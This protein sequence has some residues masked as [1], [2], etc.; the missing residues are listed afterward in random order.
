M[1]STLLTP[2]V[3]IIG[4]GPGGLN[5]AKELAGKVAGAVMVFDREAEMGGIPRHADHPGYG[6][7][8][9]KR[10]YSG[11][12][13]AQILRS[14]AQKAGAELI[15]HAMVYGW[16]D[17]NTLLAT[18]PRGLLRIQAKVF[19]FATGARERPRAARWITGDRAAGIFTTGQL[20]NLVHIQ[21][22][23]VGKRAVIV[24]GELV[25]W[26]AALT[27]QE[28]GC[29]TEALVT[30]YPKSEAYALFRTPGKIFF[31]TRVATNSKVVALHGKPRVQ[32]VEIEDIQSGKRSFIDCDTVIFTGDW[33][34]DNE[35]LRMAGVD[36]DAASLSPVVNNSMQTSRPNIFTVGNINH[37]VET[38]DVVALEGEYVAERILEYLRGKQITTPELELQVEKPLLWISPQRF[39]PRGP[40]PARGRLVSWVDDY[41]GFPTVSAYQQGQ[42]I[43]EKRL[44]WPAAPGRIFRIPAKILQKADPAKGP[45]RISIS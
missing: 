17:E 44:L 28:A 1:T 22:M 13:Y 32:S 38:A 36:L 20:Q 40:V 4:G 23:P 26:S 27:L 43:G 18:S 24:G 39:A 10:S 35:L 3:A 37:P 19:L 8:D 42:K 9:K 34:P 30:R 45:V 31:R 25:S 29:H 11:P 6:I 33:I 14:E 12:K 7:R 2:E 16:E 21:H 41:I 5:A 15:N